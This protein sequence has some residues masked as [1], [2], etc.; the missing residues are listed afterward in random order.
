MY[1]LLYNKKTSFK[2]VI[3]YEEI[4]KHPKLRDI[5]KQMAYTL[6]K[7]QCSEDKARN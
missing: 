4:I 7:C 1:I 6:Q 3:I 2:K 5:P